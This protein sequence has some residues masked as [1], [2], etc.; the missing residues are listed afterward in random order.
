MD[1][2]AVGQPEPLTGITDHEDDEELIPGFTLNEE[3]GR[4]SYA[5]CF[6]ACRKECTAPTFDLC[7]KVLMTKDHAERAHQARVELEVLKAVCGL[8]SSLPR[9]VA[10]HELP[11]ERVAII[12]QR[13]EMNLK[14]AAT[15]GLLSEDA[16]RPHVVAISGALQALHRAGFAHLDVKPANIMLVNGSSMLIDFGMAEPL[17]TGKLAFGHASHAVRRLAAAK[18]AAEDLAGGTPSY[19]AP[20]VVLADRAGLECP[21]T[22]A[23]DAWALG[24]TV[25]SVLRQGENLFRRAGDSR[26]TSKQATE[27]A[28]L[29][30]AASAISELPVSAALQHLLTRLLRAEPVARFGVD[31]IA[32]HPWA[33][34]R[35]VAKVHALSRQDSPR[36]VCALLG[37]RPSPTT[38]DVAG[39]QG[40]ATGPTGSSAQMSRRPSAS[41]LAM[42]DLRHG[43]KPTIAAARFRLARGRAGQAAALVSER[44]TPTLSVLQASLQAAAF[45]SMVGQRAY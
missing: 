15:S 22:A 33:R 14:E 17:T 30:G 13:G 25:L 8:H 29:E 9:L 12:T 44:V 21:A 27:E 1:T 31:E 2:A 7:A 20:E 18:D 28:I 36:D 40:E 11:G 16:V 37:S 45:V 10:T 39:P 32:T 23:R 19:F 38:T 42:A 3:V 6:A 43:L 41:S 34:P 24:L 26:R 4:G 5:V 35:E